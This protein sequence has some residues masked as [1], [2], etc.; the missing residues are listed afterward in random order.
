MQVSLF[1]CCVAMARELTIHR[2]PTTSS[3]AGAKVLF[4]YKKTLSVS[5]TFK[6]FLMCATTDSNFWALLTLTT[7]FLRAGA[8]PTGLKRTAT[9]SRG[10]PPAVASAAVAS[11]GRAIKTV[12]AVI[13]RGR[14]GESRPS[15]SGEAG[16]ELS[17]VDGP[18]AENGENAIVDGISS[19]LV[20][21]AGAVENIDTL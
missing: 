17:D 12:D 14:S 21:I 2:F 20:Q 9:F 16:G 11:R 4:T 18:A 15:R 6:D 8:P 5:W 19:L 1:K 7:S 3:R 13:V 10:K